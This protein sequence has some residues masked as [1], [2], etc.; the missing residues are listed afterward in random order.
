MKIIIGMAIGITLTMFYPDIIPYIK[1]AF[2]ESGVRDATVK[3]LME[4]K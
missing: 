4:V 2:I 3:T 1:D